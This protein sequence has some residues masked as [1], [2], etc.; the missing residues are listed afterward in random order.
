MLELLMSPTVW[1]SL[2]TLTFLEVVLGVDNVV[3]VSVASQRLA[4]DKQAKGR[5]IGIW[6]GAIMRVV[7]LFGL[8]ALTGLTEATLFTAPEFVRP[9]AD[10]DH[11]EVMMDFTLEDLILLIGGLFLLYKG[12]LEIHEAI[13]GHE[14]RET[15]GKVSG[16]TAVVL[17]MTVI[18]VVFS[19][20]SVLT[21]IGMTKDMGG[22]GAESARMFVMVGAVLI[23]TIIMVV[24]AKSVAGFLERHA[25]AKMLAL[26]FI[27]L[28]GMALVADGLG[29]HIPRG[30]LYFAIAFSL[31]VETLN[32]MMRQRKA[33]RL[34]AKGG[35]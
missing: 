11:P 12:T 25:T 7:L 10:P 30:Y 22:D 1:M 23:S 15:T 6:S 24:S 28:V 19:L 13:E 4:K 14:D 9:L 27:L 29:F 3:F 18:N 21:A 31:V 35:A 33:K 20:D 8:V 16:F 2:V 32:I 26:S 17:Q 34:A 5:N